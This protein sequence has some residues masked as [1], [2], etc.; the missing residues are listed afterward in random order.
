M[1]IIISCVIITT[2]MIENMFI[3]MFGIICVVIV[4]VMIIVILIS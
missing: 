2:S 1:L 3:D 4:S